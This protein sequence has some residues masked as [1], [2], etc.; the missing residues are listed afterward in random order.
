MSGASS[1]SSAAPRRQQGL[2]RRG[3]HHEIN[4][5]PCGTHPDVIQLPAMQRRAVRWVAA[6][7]CPATHSSA[8]VSMQGV[9]TLLPAVSHTRRPHQ[10]STPMVRDVGSDLDLRQKPTDVS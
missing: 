8:S 10:Y 6:R 1:F 7:C 3:A 5:T 2:S 9:A 4:A